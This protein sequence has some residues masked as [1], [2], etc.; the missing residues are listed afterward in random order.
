MEEGKKVLD[1]NQQPQR[2]DPGKPAKRCRTYQALRPRLFSSR[3]VWMELSALPL[4]V[5]LA[6]DFYLKVRL[7][8]RATFG[9]GWD[10][11]ERN[12]SRGWTGD[13]NGMQ[14]VG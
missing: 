9:F 8:I 10:C 11:F 5:N 7:L 13:R 6:C 14:S 4:E 12:H 1:A 3:S 2:R